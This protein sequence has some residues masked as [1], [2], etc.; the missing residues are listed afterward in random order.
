L[1]DQRLLLFDQL[2][3]MA[4]HEQPDVVIIAGDVYDRA[5]P[6]PAAVD[7]LDE[8]L[9][10]LAGDL[11]LPTLVIA[12][13]HDSGERLRFGA[14]LLA[15]GNL[16]VAGRVSATLRPITLT[17]IHGPVH[18]FLLP[19]ASPADVRETLDDGGVRDHQTAQVAL[20]ERARAASPS[21]ERT[22]VV[23]HTFVSGASASESERPLV[24]G[25][26]MV[27]RRVY[28]GIHYVALG[29]LHRPQKVHDA[30]I[31]YPGSLM[32]YSFSEADHDKSVSLIEMD[33][34]G[35][36]A[37]RPLPLAPPRDL[38]CV[39]GPLAGLLRDGHSDPRREDFLEVTLTDRGPVFGAIR[40][41]REVYPHTL[42]LRR[43]QQEVDRSPGGHQHD[44]RR[45]DDRE[46]FAQ[47]YQTA[48]G[49]PLATRQAEVY[50][51]LLADLRTGRGDSA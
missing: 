42:H 1:E 38:R 40:R 5:V 41:L 12:G 44:L 3:P 49:E 16:H 11:G 28:D 36:I 33:A 2:I 17:D 29:H 14:R 7:T 13:N 18:F 22:V 50:D 51:E 4:A 39:R 46:L 24:G 9:H 25:V 15:R 47:F 32:K 48:T 20:L 8:V 19:Y 21:G 30:R 26:T 37:V 34:S 27:D 6:H 31:R 10:R 45:D 23:S 35:G 43:E